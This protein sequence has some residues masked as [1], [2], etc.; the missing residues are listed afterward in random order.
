[1]LQKV[2]RFRPR[3]KD[4]EPGRGGGTVAGERVRGRG[5]RGRASTV[6]GIAAE[7]SSIFLQAIHYVPLVIK[8]TR[9]AFSGV[10]F[11]MP[12]ALSVTLR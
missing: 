8:L 9:D 11:F 10:S 12:K 1:M 2:G 5:V 6:E 7:D 3:L 4:V